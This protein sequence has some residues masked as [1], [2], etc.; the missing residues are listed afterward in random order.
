[1]YTCIIQYGSLSADDSAKDKA[2]L[3]VMKKI[4]FKLAIK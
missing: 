2:Y 4:K 3:G 1:M